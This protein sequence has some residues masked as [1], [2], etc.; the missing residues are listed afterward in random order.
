[1]GVKQMSI[2]LVSALSSIKLNAISEHI[3]WEPASV[4][5][6]LLL[7]GIDVFVYLLL[8]S[9]E[10]IFRSHR[11]AFYG[12]SL[13]IDFY[14]AIVG[15]RCYSLRFVFCLLYIVYIWRKILCFC[16]LLLPQLAFRFQGL[17]VF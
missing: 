14:V 12:V 17:M 11:V 15:L 9:H 3:G 4:R 16:S 7:L 6:S 13:A 10:E 2:T 8:K 5:A 1:M